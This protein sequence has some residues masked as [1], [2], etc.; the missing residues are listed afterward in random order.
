MAGAGDDIE[1]L[2]TVD[3]LAA[4]VRHQHAIAVA[5]EGDAQIGAMLAHRRL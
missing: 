5:V 1:Q 3:E 4:V 2:V